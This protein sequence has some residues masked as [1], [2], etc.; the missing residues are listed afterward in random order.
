MFPWHRTRMYANYMVRLFYSWLS[1]TTSFN[2][3]KVGGTV[4]R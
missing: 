4:G 2:H 1:M 3:I